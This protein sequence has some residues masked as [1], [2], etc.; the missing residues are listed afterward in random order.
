MKQQKLMALYIL[1]CVDMNKEYV[2]IALNI[3]ATLC[4]EYPNYMRYY[5]AY[6]RIGEFQWQS[7]TAEK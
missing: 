1:G 4:R 3:F 7:V 6:Q 2:I 5:E